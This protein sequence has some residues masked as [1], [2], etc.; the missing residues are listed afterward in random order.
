MPQDQLNAVNTPANTPANIYRVSVKV[1]AFNR[2]DPQ[3]W[4]AQLES[5]FGLAGVNVDETKHSYLVAN[6]DPETLRCVRDKVLNPAANDK[7]QSL[8]NTLIE[9]VGESAK[10]KINRLLS[11]IQLG[12]KKPSQL[13]R[14][15]QALSNDQITGDILQNLWLQRLPLHAQEILS[16]MEDLGLEN[17]AAKADKIVEIQRPIDIHSVGQSSAQRYDDPSAKVIAQLQQT[18]AKLQLSIESLTRQFENLSNDNTRSRSSARKS[19]PSSRDFN[20]RQRSRSRS[21]KQVAQFPNCW[22]HAKFGKDAKNCVKPCSFSE[23]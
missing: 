16:G 22:Y 15:M 8:K 5:Q 6:L 14:E 10:N 7:Y 12:D 21:A 3:L 18:N 23:N 4:F 13:L 19:S 1:S 17:L 20:K 2:D 11:G 9:R